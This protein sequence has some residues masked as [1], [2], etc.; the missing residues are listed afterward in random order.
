MPA[1]FS[2][3]GD[4]V[5]C[6]DVGMADSGTPISYEALATKTPV[7]TTTGTEIGTV[8]HVLADEHLDLFDGI[9]VKTHN[10]IRFVDRDQISAITTGAVST[11]IADADVDSLPKPEGE[12][13]FEVD[14]L[15]GIGPSLTDH[16]RKLFGREHWTRTE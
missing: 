16:L 4:S 15:Q 13:I 14:A 5:E 3:A 11:T 10:G 7:L 8:A 2:Q 1:I 12:P 9:V 6:E